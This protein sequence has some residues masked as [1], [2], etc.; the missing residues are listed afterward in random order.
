MVEVLVTS[1]SKLPMA[2]LVNGVLLELKLVIEASGYCFTVTACV[3]ELVQ[4]L[5]E[6]VAVEVTV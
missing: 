3:V 4:P 6:L 2:H 5:R 1:I